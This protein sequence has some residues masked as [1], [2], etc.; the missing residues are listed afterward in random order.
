MEQKKLKHRKTFKAN[1]LQYCYII[2]LLFSACQ[3]DP[4]GYLKQLTLLNSDLD[5]NLLNWDAISRIDMTNSDLGKDII[6]RESSITRIHGIAQFKVNEMDSAQIRPFELLLL[7]VYQ[8]KRKKWMLTSVNKSDHSM[9]DLFEFDPNILKLSTLYAAS[10][11]TSHDEIRIIFMEDQ[12]TSA[13]PKIFS[14]NIEIAE[15]GIIGDVTISEDSGEMFRRLGR[16]I[17]YTGIYQYVNNGLNISFDVKNGIDDSTYA[18]KLFV[19]SPKGCINM[20]TNLQ[21]QLKNNTIELD[22]TGTFG[23]L[24]KQNK[25]IIQHKAFHTQCNEVLV[26]DYILEKKNK[27]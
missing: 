9:I 12:S 14:H 3:Q 4:N 26:L 19:V 20:Y 10:S 6:K 7:E 17:E 16:T 13:T 27:K 5:F 8:E 22:S 15:T 2:I 11:S 21:H 25:A 18:F 23:I 1:C 24:F